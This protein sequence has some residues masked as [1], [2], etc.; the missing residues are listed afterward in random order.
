MASTEKTVTLWLYGV[1]FLLIGV[2]NVHADEIRQ[3]TLTL[4]PS[5][6]QQPHSRGTREVVVP[7]NSFQDDESA[8]ESFTFPESVDSDRVKRQ[9]S[10]LP[11]GAVRGILPA[12]PANSTSVV[13]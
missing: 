2:N 7:V 1:V 12:L 13:S 6:Q 10:T 8:Q 4:H 5:L 11:Q 9:A 3:K